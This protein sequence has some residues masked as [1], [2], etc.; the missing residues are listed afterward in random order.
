MVVAGLGRRAGRLLLARPLLSS[1][2]RG[3][4]EGVRR[5]V[6]S[7][8][9]PGAVLL[10]V[11]LSGT[12]VL[13]STEAAFTATTGNGTGWSSGTVVLGADDGGTAL[14]TASGLVPGSTGTRCIRVTYSGTITPSA[15][16]LYATSVTGSLAGYVDFV[17]E[18]GSG[19]G[20]TGNFGSCAGF[21]GST[22]YTGTAA[23]LPTT[24]ATGVGS[25][26]PAPSSF[27]VYRFTYTV[28]AGT[29]SAQQ[30]QSATVT[31]RWEAQ[32]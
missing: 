32:S 5:G 18:R 24:F 22:I 12:L 31:F 27:T 3:R 1:Q 20:N 10:G 17:I 2:R 29:P 25:F 13:Q 8:L 19:A 6:R 4:L 23:A 14:F 21:S 7:A 9:V 11:V 28:Q 16:R 26:S 30:G 15:M